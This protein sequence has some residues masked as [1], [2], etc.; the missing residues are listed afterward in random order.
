MK[1]N[2]IRDNRG[3]V[4]SKKRVGRGHGSG[5]GKT[6]G[7]G[8]KGQR[9]RSGSSTKGFSGG[10]TPIYRQL[11]K[12]GRMRGSDR[13][14]SEVKLTRIQQAID[15]GRISSEQIIS[16]DQLIT[17]GI[18]EYHVNGIKLLGGKIKSK[19]ILNVSK[20]SRSAFEEIQKAGGQVMIKGQEK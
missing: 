9:S 12:L 16:E 5:I 6:C 17:C 10:Q 20:T 1:L 19:V 7:R 15:S 13:S 8:T 2:E 14:Y 3:A 11:P 4:R 18:S